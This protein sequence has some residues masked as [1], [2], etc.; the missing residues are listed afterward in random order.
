MQP[1]V[2]A[3]IERK[4]DGRYYVSLGTP[5]PL[6]ETGMRTWQVG[7]YA[8][9]E[10]AQHIGLMMVDDLREVLARERL[11]EQRHIDD[12]RHHAESRIA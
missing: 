12:V 1:I 8:N 7:P 3:S 10:S 9:A 6:H 5:D 2:N 4:S 11:I